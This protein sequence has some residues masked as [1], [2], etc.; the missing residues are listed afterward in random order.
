M[1]N[2]SIPRLLAACVMAAA[3]LSA[4]SMA[5]AQKAALVQEVN[6][7]A[8]SPYQHNLAFNPS[9]ASCPNSY[10]C[11]AAFPAVPAGKRLV[12]TYVSAQYTVNSPSVEAIVLIGNSLFDTMAIPA[13]VNVGA[14]RFVA[15]APVTYYF[16]AGETP[17][18][19]L[20]GS[21]MS[22]SNTAHASIIGYLVSVP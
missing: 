16:E 19:F 13:A 20:S 14:S 6:V 10:Y 4:T 5:L 21:S 2:P 9:S 17:T 11:T 3:G 8:K 1:M 22:L 18:V 7:P 15:A 12:V